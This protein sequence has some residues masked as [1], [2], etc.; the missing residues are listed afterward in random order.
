MYDDLEASWC[1]RVDDCF[2]SKGLLSDDL[3][4]ALS[5]LAEEEIGEDGETDR[6]TDIAD[7]KS[8]GSDGCDKFIGASNLRDDRAGDDDAADAD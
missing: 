8:D 2:H 1:Q 3:C 7:G 5:D 6:T 4:E